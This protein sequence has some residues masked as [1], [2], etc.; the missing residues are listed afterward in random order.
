MPDEE[1]Q[2]NY[3]G[4]YLEYFEMIFNS[5]FAAYRFERSTIGTRRFI[6]TFYSG[7]SKVLIVELMPEK[8]SANK[9]REDCKKEHVPYT[10]FY[11]DHDSW[12]NT[13]KYVVTRMNEA[14]KG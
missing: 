8:C 13:R 4:T 3:K 9:F 1:N 6:Y 10:R 11:Y 2:Y 5:D 14:M 12:W 7:A